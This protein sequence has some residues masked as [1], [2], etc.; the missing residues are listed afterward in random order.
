MECNYKEVDRQLKEQFIHWLN[1]SEMLTEI[2]REPNKNDESTMIPSECVLTWAKRVEA[3]RAQEAVI[4]GLHEVK[5]FDMIQQKDEGKQRQTK[6]ATPV[7]QPIRRICKYC[8]QV[9]KQDDV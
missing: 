2:I 8:S 9:H 5:N 7:K 3:Q 6:L 1:D 4:N